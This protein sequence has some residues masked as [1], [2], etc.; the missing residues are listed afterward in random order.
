LSPPE[1]GN[2][3]NASKGSGRSKKDKFLTIEQMMNEE[4]PKIPGIRPLKNLN[5]LKNITVDRGIGLFVERKTG[6]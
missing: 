2:R 5:L 4:D 6:E 1:T 3:S